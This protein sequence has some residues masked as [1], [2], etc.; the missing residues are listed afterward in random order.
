MKLFIITCIIITTATINSIA[1][2]NNPLDKIK[3]QK[4]AFI[5]EKL[6]LTTTMAQKF[7]PVYNEF[8]SKKDSINNLRSSGRKEM[9]EK[10]DQMTTKQKEIAL[11]KQMLLKFEETK[12]EQQYY[13]KFK[14]ILAI[15]QVLKLYEAEYEFKMRLIKQLK[16]NKT[17][18]GPSCEKKPDSNCC[19][20]AESKATKI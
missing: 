1:Q 14:K 20:D 18:H 13:E 7:W 16:E 5:T 9:K 10:W 4:A 12:V 3:A 17:S 2:E 19:I 11:D 6:G 15:D 8:S